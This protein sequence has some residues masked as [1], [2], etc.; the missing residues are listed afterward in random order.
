MKT[1][2][3][4]IDVQRDYFPKGKMELTG[5]LEASLKI[6]ALLEHFRKTGKP[7]VHVQHISIRPGATFFLPETPGIEFHEN[8]TPKQGEK[9][10]VKYFPNS[11]RETG[12][13]DYLKENQISKLVI[14]GM[15]THMCVDT[16]VR[17][18]FDFGYECLVAGDCCATRTLSYKD[19]KI[20]ADSVQ[21]SFLA[22]LNGVFAKVLTKEEVLEEC[23]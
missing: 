18:A 20:E 6:R 1:A 15:M 8:V 23:K 22:A 17:A 21:N 14:T 16:T 3:L 19:K 11:F 2:L 13:G 10:F 5:S 7:V 9:I 4:I 12:L